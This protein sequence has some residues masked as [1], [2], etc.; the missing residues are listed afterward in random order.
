MDINNL[1]PIVL[2]V[3]NRPNHTKKT[4]EYLQKNFHSQQSNLFI[5]SDAPK[6]KEAE[7]KVKE[8]RKYI[9][10]I[11]GFREIYVIE[12]DKNWGLAN[13]VINGVT[14]IINKYGRVIVLEDDL[15]TSPYFLEFMNQALITYRDRQDIFS[16]TG[17][18]FEKKF[19]KFDNNYT[20]D[21]YLN[22]RPMSWSW[23]TWSNKWKNIDW[24]VSDYNEFKGDQNKINKFNS[25]G[26]D[27]A[28][29]LNNQMNN[30]IDSWYIR[31]SYYA[32]MQDLYTIYPK[33]SLVNNLGHDGSGVHCSDNNFH[34]S[35]NELNQHGVLKINQNINLD[36]KIIRNFN[37]GFN[38]HSSAEKL[39]IKLL[40]F[41]GLF[42][43]LKKIRSKIKQS[44]YKWN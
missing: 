31:W 6:N 9:K 29:M 15:I 39:I 42:N 8:V 11:E 36:K 22:I 18:S 27:L 17:F 4:L 16:I 37:K 19:M 34:Y 7:S 5:F 32:I 3:Y 26:T 13:S 41:F 10:S 12:R 33:I 21:V 30:K 43:F 40:K 14:D 38:L 35:H 44:H 1:A 28:E 24:E 23:A 25:G 20:E 2:F